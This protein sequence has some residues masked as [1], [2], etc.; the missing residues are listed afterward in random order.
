VQ[1]Q[2]F[3]YMRKL[4]SNIILA[5]I[6]GLAAVN[7]ANRGTPDGGPKDETPPIITKSEPENFTTEFNSKE[8]KIYFDEYIKIKDLQKNLIISPPMDPMPEIK[9]LGSASKHIT[10]KIFDTL[11]PNTTYAFNFG[12]SI[13]DNNEG[14]PY[15]YYKY[16]FSTGTFIDSLKIKGS[17][18]DALDQKTE[19]FVS[20][21]L[22]DVDSTFTDSIIYKEKPKYISNTLDSTNTFQLENL[23]A[24]KYLMVAIKDKSSNYTFDQDED[25]IDFLEDFITIPSDFV[26]E[27]NLFK[28][29]LDFEILRAKQDSENKIIF[30]LEGSNENVDIKL[31]SKN[32][33]DFRYRVINDTESDSLHYFYEPSIKQDSLIFKVSKNNIVDTLVVKIRE[34]EKDSLIVK[35]SPRGN[36]SFIEDFKIQGNIPFAKIDNSKINFIDKDS[37]DVSY[38]TRLDTLNNL[39]QFN[40]EKTEENNYNIKLFPGALIDLFGDQNDTISYTLRTKTKSDFGDIRLTLRNAVYPVIVQLT[41]SKGEVK[42]EQYIETEKPIDFR[43]ITPGKYVLRVIF[44]SNKNKKYDSGNYLQKRKP[45]RVSYYPDELDVRAGWDLIQEFI[46]K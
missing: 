7:C 40:F 8:I 20:I 12:E 4:I 13:T 42:F 28:E 43:H 30:G 32:P 5:I 31:L 9:P 3:E 38:T 2:D 17:V 45:E 25:K 1:N 35:A 23:K 15:P 37:V 34:R 41:T 27:F 36:I 46:L 22:Y 11:Q 33:N 29:D 24:G 6:I 26:Y 14:N 39:Y 21:M 19:E 16:V 44:D 10:I 18:K